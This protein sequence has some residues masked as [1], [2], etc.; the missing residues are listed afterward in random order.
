MIFATAFSESSLQVRRSEPPVPP[1]SRE[2][3]KA[4]CPS[5]FSRLLQ[6][7]P[8]RRRHFLTHEFA[9]DQA[10]EL[11]SEERQHPTEARCRCRISR[12]RQDSLRSATAR[13]E[14]PQ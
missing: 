7:D 6:N 2:L 10:P 8:A 11:K 4:F 1:V 3:Q 14:F 12:I 9:Q 13:I 5:R